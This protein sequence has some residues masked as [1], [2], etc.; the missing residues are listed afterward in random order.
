[1]SEASDKRNLKILAPIVVV[2]FIVGAIASS[3]SDKKTP[4]KPTPSQ[5]AAIAKTERQKQLLA[6]GATVRWR[7]YMKL[8]L[9]SQALKTGSKPGSITIDPAKAS[10]LTLNDDTYDGLNSVP[11]SADATFVTP[12][13]ASDAHIY[14]AVMAGGKGQPWAVL[15]DSFSD[16]TP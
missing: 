7:E 8:Y 10:E 16:D 5:A 14:T 1:M 15:Q 4:P 12:L 2:V 9:A 3:G 13:G 11:V 6:K